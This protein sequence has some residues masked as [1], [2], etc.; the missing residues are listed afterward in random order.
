MK[1]TN[2]D[3]STKGARYGFNGS[4]FWEELSAGKPGCTTR[5]ERDYWRIS[6]TPRSKENTSVF[7]R[8]SP[9]RE[10]RGYSQRFEQTSFLVRF[11]SIG[12][13]VQLFPTHKVACLA[14]KKPKRKLGRPANRQ[15]RKGEGAIARNSISLSPLLPI[16]LSPLLLTRLSKEMYQITYLPV[17]VR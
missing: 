4:S 14:N 5:L 1:Q 3:G 15:G 17:I 6:R 9:I 7:F 8:I 13:S 10:S 11:C 16:S 2:S 12:H